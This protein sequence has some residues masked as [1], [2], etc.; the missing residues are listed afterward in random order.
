MN[1]STPQGKGIQRTLHLLS[2]AKMEL[3]YLAIDEKINPAVRKKFQRYADKFVG[4]VI[5]DFKTDMSSTDG[6]IVT[7]DLTSERALDL[8]LLIEFVLRFE[9]IGEITEVLKS[10]YDSQNQ[11]QAA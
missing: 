9:N 4:Y 6:N 10:G 2:M 1:A 3:E 5:R 8:S 11:L 7:D